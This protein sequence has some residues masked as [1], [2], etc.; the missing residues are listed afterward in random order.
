MSDLSQGIIKAH[1]QGLQV[2]S[3]EKESEYIKQVNNWTL[4]HTQPTHKITKTFQ[5]QSFPEAISFVN[6]IA[7]LAQKENHHPNILIYFKKVTLEFTTNHLQGL[8]END[9]IM[10]AKVDEIQI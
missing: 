1:G 8:T 2:F 7:D 4:D 5:F 10:A 9:F 3:E 6:K